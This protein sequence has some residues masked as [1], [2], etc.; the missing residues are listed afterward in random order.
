MY[1]DNVSFHIWHQPPQT[2][3]FDRGKGSGNARMNRRRLNR[4]RQ[5]SVKMA[6]GGEVVTN[7]YVS[8]ELPIVCVSKGL[9]DK[10]ERVRKRE[11]RRM[12]QAAAAMAANSE[13]RKKLKRQRKLGIKC[14]ETHAELSGS[15][16]GDDEELLDEN[17][18]P[19]LS[20]KHYTVLCVFKHLLFIF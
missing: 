13:E 14:I 8:T 1:D 6:A 9:K 10:Q 17:G 20:G 18:S 7:S 3:V 11:E 16:S 15:D 12:R 2:P 5:N 4:L 19:K